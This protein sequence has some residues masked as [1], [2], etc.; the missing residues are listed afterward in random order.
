MLFN[1]A[2]P[3]LG[4]QLSNKSINASG[5]THTTMFTALLF[6]AAKIDADDKEKVKRIY[7]VEQFAAT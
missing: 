3:L 2:I 5:H 7:T 6:V 4:T 1:A